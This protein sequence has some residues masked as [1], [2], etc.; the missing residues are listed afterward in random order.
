MIVE[1]ALTERADEEKF[2]PNRNCC[3]EDKIAKTFPSAAPLSSDGCKG[4]LRWRCPMYF[5]HI[6]FVRIAQLHARCV[7]HIDRRRHIGAALGRRR[8]HWMP[9][10]VHR[11]RTDGARSQVSSNAPN[12]RSLTHPIPLDLR[13]AVAA[14]HYKRATAVATCEYVCRRS[15]DKKWRDDCGPCRQPVSFYGFT[16]WGRRR[17]DR[18]LI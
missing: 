12:V 13:S 17:T 10:L 7:G 18:P 11:G 15:Y 5:H 3:D 1:S 14:A 6:M 2:S 4:I 16:N 9:S 8:R